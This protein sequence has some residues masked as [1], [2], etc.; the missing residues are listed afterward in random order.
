MAEAGMSTDQDRFSCP[1]CLELLK[2]PVTTP[3]GHNFC[4]MCINGFWDKEDQKGIYSCPQCRETFTPRPVLRR[5]NMLAE[6]VEELKKT[7]LQAAS[8][9]RCYAR[10]DVECDSCTGRKRKALRTCLVC[11][12]SYCK[13]HLQPH[14]Y[15]P[16]FK[17]HKLVEACAE[18]KEKI[19]SEHDK[20]LGIYCRTDQ[21]L[22]CYLCTLDRHKGHD[23]V[24]TEAKRTEKQ[25][26]LKKEQMKS[27]QR[28]QE[29]LKKVQELKQTVD[30]I[31][32]RSQEA[33]FDSER[34]FNELISSMEKKRSEVTELI[35]AQEKAELSPVERLL[36]Q[37]E[38]EIADLKRRVTEMEQLSH[39]HD[40]IHFLQSF[41]SLCVSPGCDDSLNFT[42]NQHLSFDGVRKSLSG[43]KK[44][45]EQICEKK[46]KKVCV[47]AAAIQMILP[48]EL[49][50]RKD[51]L[52]YF[53]YLTLDPNTAHRELI[54]SEKNRVVTWSKTQQQYPDHPERFDSGPQVLCKESVCGCCYW[55]VERSGV[56]SISV[57]YKEISRKVEGY[58]C[59]F[60]YNNQ[61]WSLRCSPSS[62]FFMHN[63]IETELQGPV[64]S[65]I[66]VYVD[67]SAGT[68]S[69]YSVSDVMR[70]LHRV[71]TTFTQLLYAGFWI[72][73]YDSQVSLCDPK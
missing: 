50:S 21:S 36:N 18:L 12:A 32:R 19:C 65:R 34:I 5:N 31:K 59:L 53:R 23:T 29:K 61:S 58:E 28:I 27:Q 67:H 9:A 56:V 25:N 26:E 14:Y 51:F 7:E 17:K 1:V 45:V 41:P 8:P 49:K 40:D 3:C 13:D 6:M 63:N 30:I 35:R 4:K 11:L 44:H 43:L 64:T 33:A 62:V 54:L 70:L 71:H 2:D 69:F 52:L 73:S 46:V 42:V 47:E 57:S 72:R 66:G 24:T 37:L 15:S 16:A 22:I 39:T 68:L 10:P 60:G 48:S 38:Q 20:L 55:E